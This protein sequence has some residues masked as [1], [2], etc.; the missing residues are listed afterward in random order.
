MQEQAQ[1]ESVQDA[2]EE[3]KSEAASSVAAKSLKSKRKLVDPKKQAIAEESK[4]GATS[5]AA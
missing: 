1:E 5:E 3:N 4:E 2:P